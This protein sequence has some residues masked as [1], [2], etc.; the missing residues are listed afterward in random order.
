[1]A[2]WRPCWCRTARLRV[3]DAILV[4]RVS[5]RIR[6]MLNDKGKPIREALPSTPVSILG[7]SDVPQPGDILEVVDNESVARSIA[8]AARAEGA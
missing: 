4:G 1:M 3:G 7:L 6:N 5:G 2:R 8:G